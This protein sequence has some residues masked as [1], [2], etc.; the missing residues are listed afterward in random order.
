MRA[1]VY[2]S[3]FG[4]SLARQTGSMAPEVNSLDTIVAPVAGTFVMTSAVAGAEPTAFTGLT[5]INLVRQGLPSTTALGT[6]FTCGLSR[7]S[8]RRVLRLATG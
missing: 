8:S 2:L 5:E 3:R 7:C 1:P 6:K 4:R